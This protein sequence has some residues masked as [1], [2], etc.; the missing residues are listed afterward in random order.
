MSQMISYK[1]IVVLGV[2]YLF[3]YRVGSA[4]CFVS[5]TR[6]CSPTPRCVSLRLY[7]MLLSFCYSQEGGTDNKDGFPDVDAV[8]SAIGSDDDVVYSKP[9][10]LQVS[11]GYTW[12][13]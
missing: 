11:R 5:G 10:A 3:T 12:P 9:T 13:V 2:R 1:E 7:F 8:V 6:T 4:G